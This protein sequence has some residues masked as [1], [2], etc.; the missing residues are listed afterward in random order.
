MGFW[1]IAMRSRGFHQLCA[2]AFSASPRLCATHKSFW[3]RV[4]RRGAET[5]SFPEELAVTVVAFS[6]RDRVFDR[7][8]WRVSAR[9][10]V[11]ARGVLR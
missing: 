10:G 11:R 6:P 9:R 4:S 7:L 5:Q 8:L 3:K 2:V 1:I